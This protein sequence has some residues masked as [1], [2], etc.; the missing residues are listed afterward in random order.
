MNNNFDIGLQLMDLLDQIAP[1][2]EINWFS[3]KYIKKMIK[4]WE[5][6]KNKRIRKKQLKKI[7]KFD[8]PGVLS[9]FVWLSLMSVFVKT[10]KNA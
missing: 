10:L 9:C 4:K 2:V 1:V 6:S 8:A 3:K 7:D 5:L